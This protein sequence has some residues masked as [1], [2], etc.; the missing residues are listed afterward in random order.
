M[1]TELK[2][3]I[4]WWDG[5]NQV[6]PDDVPGLILSGCSLDKIVV[7]EL[8]DDLKLFNL[9]EEVQIKTEKSENDDFDKSWDI[10]ERYQ[11]LNIE[12]YLFEQSVEFYYT[13]SIDKEMRTKYDKRLEDE[14]KE[15]KSR[16]LEI[17]LRTLV[18]IVDTFKQSKTVWGVGRGSSCASLALFL[19]GLHKV[20]PIKYNIPLTEFFH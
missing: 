3:R 8:N 12:E 20:D 7:D 5:T 18:Y 15:I 16:N 17:L 1:K 13:K 11:K 9:I 2:D 4:L 14:M 19:I 6:N 10:P